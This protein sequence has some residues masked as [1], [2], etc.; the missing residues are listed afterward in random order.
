M[1]KII[2]LTMLCLGIYQSQAQEIY[3]STGKTGKA[4]YKENQTKK[5]FDPHK[6]VFGGG[7]G[8]GFGTI[9][10]IYVAPSIGYRLTDK[11]TAGVSLGYNYFNQ[12][13]AFDSYNLN[14]G[15]TR[16]ESFTQSIYSA[17]VWGRYFV[18]QNFMVQAEFEVN[19]IGF[20]NYDE[21]LHDAQG[22]SYY[23]QNRLSI[24]S[25]LLGG[26]YRQ[27]IGE[28]SYFFVMAFYDVLQDISSNMRT[29]YT[30]ER[31]SLSPYA[32]RIDLRVGFALGL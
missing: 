3:N 31:Y 26:G 25:L 21:T 4:K 22:W 15:D 12:K 18:L 5:G 13:D 11:F 6:L 9:T 16:T 8:L 24:P 32:N 29:D 27:P 17:S 19:N 14:S 10:N 1:K 2:L 23:A 30:G 20:Y 7:L 28:H